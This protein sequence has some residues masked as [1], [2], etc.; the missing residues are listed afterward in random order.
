[1]YLSLLD[2]DGAAGPGFCYAVFVLH[3]QRACVSVSICRH[4]L[5]KK[6]LAR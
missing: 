6:A 4:P 3:T 5:P 2:M 1:M